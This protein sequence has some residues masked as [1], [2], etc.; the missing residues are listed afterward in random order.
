[1]TGSLKY[2]NLAKAVGVMASFV[3]SRRISASLPRMVVSSEAIFR[4]F[5]SSSLILTKKYSIPA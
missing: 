3:A 4:S 5:L 1:M 2:L